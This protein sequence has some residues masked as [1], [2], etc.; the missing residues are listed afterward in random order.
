MGYNNPMPKDHGMKSA[1]VIALAA[2]GISLT[3]AGIVFFATGYR[4]N[5]AK[6]PDNQNNGIIQ[7]T[8][9]ISAISEPKS[10]SVYI[11]DKLTTATD[12]TLTL[13]PG[14][15]T[16]RI[17]KDG[18]LPW[19][20]TFQVKKEVV[21]QT[22]TLLFRSAPLLEPITGAGSET[23]SSST[24][25]SL[26]F[27]YVASASATKN[28]GLYVF[29]LNRNPLYLLQN[30]PRQL[31]PALSEI[32]LSKATYLFSPNNNQVIASV[33]NIHYLLEL[34][35]NP[36]NRPLSRI[37]S[38]IEFNT[39]ETEWKKQ[40]NDIRTAQIQRLPEVLR[41]FIS[42]DS[43]KLAVLNT[44]GDK[45]IYEASSSGILASQ[46]RN[47]LPA[48]S[49]Q[50]QSRNIEAPNLYIYDLKDDTN[51]LLGSPE[52]LKNTQWL[53]DTSNVIFVE[54]NTIYASDYDATNKQKLYAGD[55]DNKVLLSTSDGKK[56][57]VL[58]S[59]YSG[60][61]KNLYAITIR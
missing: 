43:A 41:S 7:L 57:I 17:A 23:A 10:A 61:P 30:N 48:Q 22:N 53:G 52:N 25:R 29:D 58:T 24:D 14:S 9:L 46:D 31:S 2:L 4:F 35:A 50:T 37:I 20:K 51:F 28:N 13:N 21:N 8:G 27:F 45:I 16:I 36:L 12:D 47:P 3:T 19:E 33:K 40:L 44:N 6:D 18:Y 49:T 5:F 60:A 1:S 15:Y 42:T 34:G 32:D 39:L 55:F 56:I 38:T 59:A 26:L 54:S 11:N